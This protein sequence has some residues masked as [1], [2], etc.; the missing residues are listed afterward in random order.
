MIFLTQ[1]TA[2]WFGV[3]N[4][5]EAREL[6]NQIAEQNKGMRNKMYFMVMGT[7]SD[8]D[9]DA[10]ATNKEGKETEQALEHL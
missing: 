10:K 4:V 7:G 6:G 1:Y 2:L 5:N 8:I 9:F 3:S